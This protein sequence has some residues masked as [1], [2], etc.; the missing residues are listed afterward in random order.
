[1]KAIAP[2]KADAPANAAEPPATAE[3][4]AKASPTEKPDRSPKAAQSTPSVIIDLKSVAPE[5]SAE[6]R[7]ARSRRRRRTALLA[8]TVVAA[9]VLI[10]FLARQFNRSE[11]GLLPR[12]PPADE[13]VPVQT[14]A[15][16]PPGPEAP[17]TSARDTAAST[18][19]SASPDV[20]ASAQVAP[21][22]PRTLYDPSQI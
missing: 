10:I 8:M 21:A 4:P 7:L 14:A 17:I 11:P 1:V 5:A 22:R 6:V 3:A 18:M 12:A 20:P 9:A 16:P 13:A 19:R 15:L 2:P